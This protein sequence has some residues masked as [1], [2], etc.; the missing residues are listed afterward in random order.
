MAGGTKQGQ[1]QEGFTFENKS[2]AVKLSGII[3]KI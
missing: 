2:V 3:V 1:P